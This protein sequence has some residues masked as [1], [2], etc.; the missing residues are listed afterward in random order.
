MD[1]EPSTPITSRSGQRS[2]INQT[3]GNWRLPSG[4]EPLHDGIITG[5]EVSVGVGRH[6]G[7]IE[8]QFR[9]TAALQ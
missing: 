9:L 1:S 4:S 3:G 7:G 2:Q 5:G 8:H 6:L